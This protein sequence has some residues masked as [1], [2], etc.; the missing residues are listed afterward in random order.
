VAENDALKAILFV[1]QLATQCVPPAY[2]DAVEARCESNFLADAEEQL[3]PITI[4][5]TVEIIDALLRRKAPGPDGITNVMLKQLL[6]VAVEQ[7]CCLIH[8]T[9]AL[10]PFPMCWKQVT[11][12]MLPKA[13]RPASSPRKYRTISLLSAV[14]K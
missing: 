12:V 6:R 3:E 5:G 8:S 2:L 9:L 4:L 11:V 13:P 10:G 14:G 1:D 7:L